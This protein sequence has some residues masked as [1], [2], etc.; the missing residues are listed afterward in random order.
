MNIRIKCVIKYKDKVQ[1]KLIIRILCSQDKCWDAARGPGAEPP[2]SL[3]SVRE[4]WVSEANPV[5]SAWVHSL[6]RAIKHIYPITSDFDKDREIL[7]THAGQ[8]NL[9]AQ[10][11]VLNMVDEQICV[12]QC[13][14][15]VGS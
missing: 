2:A 10:I 5:P 8:R 15:S 6:Y 11:E 4:A 1:Q 14:F 13:L 9:E 12:N 3:E 7:Y